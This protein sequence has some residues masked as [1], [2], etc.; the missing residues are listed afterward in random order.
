MRSQTMPTAYRSAPL[1]GAIQDFPL[2]PRQRP[3]PR[4]FAS[5]AQTVITPPTPPLPIPENPVPPPSE[6]PY[7]SGPVGVP[8]PTENP[9]PVREPPVTLPPQL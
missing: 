1:S 8:P 7:P 9:T 6:V 3:I 5:W 4:L 2:E